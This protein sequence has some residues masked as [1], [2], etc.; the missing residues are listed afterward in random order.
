MMTKEEYKSWVS[1]MR[2]LGELERLRQTRERADPEGLK[3]F[4]SFLDDIHAI[5]RKNNSPILEDMSATNVRI[6]R[7][8]ILSR[9][10]LR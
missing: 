2:T 9:Y 8:K 10:P 6:A 1:R 4:L 3:K 5:W 7:Q